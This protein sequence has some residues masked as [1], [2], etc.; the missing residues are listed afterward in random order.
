MATKK[1]VKKK[2]AKNDV[3]KMVVGNAVV[4]RKS[5]KPKSER[6][7]MIA[8]RS[9]IIID[10]KKEINKIKDCEEKEALKA[11]IEKREKALAKILKKPAYKGL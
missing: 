10:L 2:V 6:E 7:R 3:E 8:L 9:S 1:V 5:L 11:H 4:K